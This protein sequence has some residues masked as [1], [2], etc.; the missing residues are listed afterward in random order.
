MKKLRFGVIGLG[1]MGDI[2]ARVFADLPEAEL[3]ACCDIVPERAAALAAELG[4]SGYAGDDYREMLRR[5]PDLDGVAVTTPVEVED[6][7]ARH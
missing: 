1:H 6:S 7:I 5:H 3:V 2:Y 4:V